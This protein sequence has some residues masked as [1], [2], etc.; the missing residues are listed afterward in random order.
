LDLSGAQLLEGGHLFV[1]RARVYMN[2]LSFGRSLQISRVTIS[3]EKP[4]ILALQDADAGSMTFAHVDMGRCVFYGSHDLGS[5][6]NEPTVKFARTPAWGYSRRRCIADE[7][8]WRHHTGGFR[9]WRWS[10]P[11]TRVAV[12]DHESDSSDDVVDLPELRASQVAAVYRNLRRSFE[13]KSDAPGAADF[14]YGEMEMRRHSRE[15]GV[16]EQAIIWLY[17]ILS[18]YSLRASRA[19]GWLLALIVSCTIA[20]AYFGFK[21][22]PATYL[23]SF[24]FSLQA[25]LP[26]LQSD[27]S[28]T[29]IGELV[30]I[31]LTL[32]A[33]LLFALALLALRG[34]VKR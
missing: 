25:A 18:G 30:E 12:D 28:L 34:R 24:I 1:E 9:S 5:V 14:Y 6:V 7:F 2:Q 31:G 29:T 27:S 10:L 23:D 17:W 16:A 8:A 4:P 19:F 20:M 21:E 13:A 33:P 3:T 11:G 32:L 15:A 26:G 22:E